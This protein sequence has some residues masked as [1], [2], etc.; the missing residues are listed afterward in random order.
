VLA[1]VK[2][3]VIGGFGLGRTTVDWDG[4]VLGETTE[5]DSAS[6]V[7]SGGDCLRDVFR[8]YNQRLMGFRRRTK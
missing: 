3:V 1:G 2:M 5:V 7:T 4:M 8:I 6:R